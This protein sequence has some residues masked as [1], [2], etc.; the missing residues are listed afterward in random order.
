ML[1]KFS[2]SNKC[3]AFEP[4]IYKGEKK[5]HSFHKNIVQHNCFNI[6]N[7][8]KRFLISKSVYYYDFW[9]SCDTEDWSN[10]AENTDLVK[11]MFYIL[12]ILF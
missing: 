7:N 9:R 8:Q 5:H 4:S 12:L 3:S 10:D 11:G 6:D 1:Q 2:V